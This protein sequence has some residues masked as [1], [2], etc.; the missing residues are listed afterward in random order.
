MS[1]NPHIFKRSIKENIEIGWY[2]PDTEILTRILKTLQL[3]ETIKT[4]PQGINTILN[5]DGV[6]L[7]EGQKQRI[8]L[9]RALIREPQFLLLDE[10]TSGLDH[11]I[12]KSIIDDLL[13]LIDK[14]TI[15]CIT[16]SQYVAS[17][18]DRI[19]YLPDIIEN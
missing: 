4:L 11:D 8:A 19:I 18:M 1:Q 12:E 2:I 13:K 17:K 9:G 5:K 7:S 16:H 6:S 14:Q 15:I 3:S 10:F